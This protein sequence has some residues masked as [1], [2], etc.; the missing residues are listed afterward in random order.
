[1]YEVRLIDAPVGMF[2][3]NGTLALKTEYGRYVGENNTY[4]PNCFL[5]ETGEYFWGG[6]HTVEELNN[7]MVA[8]LEIDKIMFDDEDRRIGNWIPKQV[9]STTVLHECSNCHERFRFSFSMKTGN[10]Y[11]ENYCSKCGSKNTS[12]EKYSY[13][14]EAE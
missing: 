4:T 7:L 12:I 8:P 9:D 2:M 11:P 5:V 10:Y 1:M 13:L 6:A 14:Y 3:Y